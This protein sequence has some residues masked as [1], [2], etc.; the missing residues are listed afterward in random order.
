MCSLLVLIKAVSLVVIAQ[1]GLLNG[2]L[3]SH[4]QM[5]NLPSALGGIQKLLMYLTWMASYFH[6]FKVCQNAIKHV[7]KP[8]LYRLYH[9]AC[10]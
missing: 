10:Y 6:C 4:T 1:L 7:L 5:S 3:Q 9:G 2:Y 8:I